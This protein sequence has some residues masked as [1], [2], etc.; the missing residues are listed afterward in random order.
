VKQQPVLANFPSHVFATAQRKFQAGM[1]RLRES[2]A[3]QSLS[4]YS[5]MFADVLPA[6]FL[7]RID[8]TRR[9]RHFGH[10]PVFW[11]WLAQVLE[12]NASCSKAIGF[13]Q[14]WCR[15]QGLPVP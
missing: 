14:S 12:G 11:A 1:R 9:N 15:V 7:K 8:P 10:I 6:D 3:G 13:V 4:G 2:L 5:V